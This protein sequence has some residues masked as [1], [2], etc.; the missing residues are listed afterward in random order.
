MA[1]TDR[2]KLTHQVRQFDRNPGRGESIL[3]TV[4]SPSPAAVTAENHSLARARATG[5]THEYHVAPERFAHRDEVRNVNDSN[6]I[7]K[8]PDLDEGVL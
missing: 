6:S 1:W 7:R 2:P 5:V 8:R 3:P 4:A